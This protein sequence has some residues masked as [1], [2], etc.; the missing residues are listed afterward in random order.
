[1][2]AHDNIIKVYAVY[3]T[4]NNVYVITEFCE[5]RLNNVR[6]EDYES[7]AMGI[8]N[9]LKHLYQHNIIHRDLKTD[10]IMLKGCTPKIIDFGFARVLSHPEE[11]LT[12]YLGTPLY[13]APQIQ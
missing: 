3:Q 2:P 7:V 13:M 4:V 9:G 1:M 8:A 11:R 10:N 6:T 5:G 12:E